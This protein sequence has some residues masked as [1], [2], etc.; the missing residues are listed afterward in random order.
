MPTTYVAA[1]TLETVISPV[2]ELDQSNA[3]D[4]LSA[5]RESDT[6]SVVLDLAAVTFLDSSMLDVCVRASRYLE[7]TD[8]QLQIVNAVGA[9]RRVFE[10]TGLVEMLEKSSAL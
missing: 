4:V 1:S 5:I 6:P 8:R 7:S 3:E 9:V 2:G 10:I